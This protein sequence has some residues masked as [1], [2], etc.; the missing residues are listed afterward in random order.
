[1]VTHFNATSA[2]SPYKRHQALPIMFSPW[3]F[4]SGWSTS[5]LTCIPSRHAYPISQTLLY[6]VPHRAIP[7][8]VA[9]ALTRRKE[10]DSES[11]LNIHTDKG[12]HNTPRNDNVSLAPEQDPVL[13]L[14]SKRNLKVRVQDLIIASLEAVSF[15]QFHSR[16]LQQ[17]I[18]ETTWK[19]QALSTDLAMIL[20][21]QKR[22]SF[23]WW[24]TRPVPSV[25]K[26][27]LPYNGK[28]LQEM[29]SPYALYTW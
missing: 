19:K 6:W 2:K 24:Y 28:S 12:L 21:S 25:E 5:G 8:L 27:F 16:T 29:Q 17:N 4:V 1:M 26:S 7:L 22:T 23:S 20:L 11:Q 14:R 9:M 15:A 10:A 18:L 13:T 3:G